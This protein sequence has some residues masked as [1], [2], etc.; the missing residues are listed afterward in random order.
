MNNKLTLFTFILLLVILFLINL[1]EQSIYLPGGKAIETDKT[2]I[3]EL[4]EFMTVKLMETPYQA[5]IHEIIKVERQIVNG[6]NYY[7]TMHV[8][9]NEKIKQLVEAKVFEPMHHVHA[10]EL[11]SIDKK[12]SIKSISNQALESIPGG[13]NKE[14]DYLKITEL[15]NFLQQKLI[16][17]ENQSV[18][19]KV[20]SI[21]KQVV[22][23]INYFLD[24]HLEFADGKVK[25]MQA[26]IHEPPIFA[27]SSS[28]HLKSL[29]EINGKE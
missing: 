13:R 8:I 21:E 19:R 1:S 3:K 5:K 28:L 26:T 9:S 6:V 16:E 24:V 25:L 18:I 4:M 20:I 7:I 2:K 22:A 10:F 29:I 27:G 23:G 11:V 12:D 15:V 17:S 14:T